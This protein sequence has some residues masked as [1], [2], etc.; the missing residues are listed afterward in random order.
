MGVLTVGVLTVGAMNV[1]VLTVGA[2]TVGSIDCRINVTTPKFLDKKLKLTPE[3]IGILRN[4]CDIT[5]DMCFPSDSGE[6]QKC[7]RHYFG[8]FGGL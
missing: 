5:G 8:S 2:M 1:G 3:R 4:V 6:C 7:Y